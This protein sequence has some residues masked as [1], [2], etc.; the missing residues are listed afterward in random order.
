M[1]SGDRPF[2]ALMD[3][4]A[5]KATGELICV[6]KA[7]EVHLFLQRGRVAWATDSDHAFAFTRYLQ[8]TAQ[9]D[10]DAFR[11]ILDSCRREKRPLGETLVSWGVTTREEVREALAHQICLALQVLRRVGGARTVFLDRT[12]Q[13]APYD[14]SFTFDVREIVE[15]AEGGSSEAARGGESPPRD[16]VEAEP[17]S[18]KGPPPSR[19]AR[20]LIER[21]EGI[22]WAELFDGTTLLECA[23]EP[24]P[25]PRFPREIIERT[26]LDGAELVALR[27]PEG[28]LAGVAL[29]ASQSLWCRLGA[30]ATVGAAISALGAFGVTSS[31]RPHDAPPLASGWTKPWSIGD[32]DAPPLK[33]L[34]CFV[35]RAPETLAAVL[36]SSDE[37]GDG[38][39]LGVGSSAVDDQWTLSLARRRAAVLGAQPFESPEQPED[40]V[41]FRFRSMVTGEARV[42]CFGAELATHP[43]CMVWLLLD[44]R[45]TQGL[46]WAYLTS[47]SR[48]LLHLR[49]WGTRG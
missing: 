24:S 22:E 38:W 43:R 23:P 46:G 6:S 14:S 7:G 21:V 47:L 3:L 48:Q 31:S 17:S 26:V 45:T 9:I 8:R 34:R 1:I 12:A 44:R 2:D 37:G 5:A 40:D 29:P 18:V 13:F 11:D 4:A 49:D 30:D 33:E 16:P 27:S 25:R 10:A 41:G 36:T 42:W 32:G 19:H 20:R 35:D 39:T 15:L 28:T